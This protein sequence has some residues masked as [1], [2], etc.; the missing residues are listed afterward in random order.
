MAGKT[1]SADV[2]AIASARSWA[3]VSRR[4]QRLAIWRHAGLCPNLS[5]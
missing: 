1:I 4:A 3:V 5:E 2:D